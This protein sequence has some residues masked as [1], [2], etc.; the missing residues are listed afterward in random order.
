[1]LNL[2]K[3]YKLWNVKFKKNRLLLFDP[4]LDLNFNQL[5]NYLTN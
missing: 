1:M 3:F 5:T 2:R 4:T